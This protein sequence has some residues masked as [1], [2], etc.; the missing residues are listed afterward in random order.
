MTVKI[1]DELVR[2]GAFK[3]KGEARNMIKNGG[4]SLVPC[5]DEDYEVPCFEVFEEQDGTY[6]YSEEVNGEKQYYKNGYV[7]SPDGEHIPAKMWDVRDCNIG[8]LQFR[9]KLM[10]DTAH[11]S[12]YSLSIKNPNRGAQY[13]P[14]KYFKDGKPIILIIFIMIF[15]SF[16]KFFLSK[17]S[18]LN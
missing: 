7:L 3:S 18:S 15:F 12:F 9:E 11:N 16:I 6:Q 13:C 1:I 2:V 10:H 5:I 14:V 17:R 8:L 4:V